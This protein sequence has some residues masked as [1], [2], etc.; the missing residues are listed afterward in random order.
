MGN[1][2][3][4]AIV[5]AALLLPAFAGAQVTQ[6]LGSSRP[7]IFSGSDW[8]EALDKVPCESIKVNKNGTRT[9]DGILAVGKEKERNPT[10]SDADGLAIIESH[11]H[12]CPHTL[13]TLGIA[14]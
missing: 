4:L 7:P 6:N 14:C 1:R 3:L 8:Q 12:V 11:C 5:A 9:V 13:K 2:S 10:I